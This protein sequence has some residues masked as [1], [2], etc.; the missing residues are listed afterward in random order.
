[1]SAPT[2]TCCA[3]P[4]T[5]T[6]TGLE[7]THAAFALTDAGVIDHQGLRIQPDQMTAYERDRYSHWLAS[8][9]DRQ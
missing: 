3:N 1:M 5:R 2:A 8:R 9:K 4:M 7:C 6:A